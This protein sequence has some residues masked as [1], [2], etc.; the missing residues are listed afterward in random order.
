[1]H[2]KSLLALVSGVSLLSGLALGAYLGTPVQRSELSKAGQTI[3]LQ[4]K[5]I[6]SQND[7]IKK[8]MHTTTVAI[9]SFS[10]LVGC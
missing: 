2:P 5:V 3:E 6:A 4:N 7:T 10:G 1:M 8:Y 9:D